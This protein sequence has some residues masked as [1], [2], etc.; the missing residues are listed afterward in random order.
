MTN[1][2]YYRPGVILT[3]TGL[4]NG[5][6]RDISFIYHGVTLREA[7]KIA[8][9]ISLGALNEIQL[10]TESLYGTDKIGSKL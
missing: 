9:K 8:V 6:S 4:K 7:L 2:I 10:L 1:S 3:N 5:G